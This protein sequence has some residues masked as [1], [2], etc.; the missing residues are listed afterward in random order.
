MPGHVHLLGHCAPGQ[1][2]LVAERLDAELAVGEHR[3]DLLAGVVELVPGGRWALRVEAGLGEDVLVPVEHPLRFQEQGVAVPGAV[4]LGDLRCGLG[5][6]LE[7]LGGHQIIQGQV[8]AQ[9]DAVV[10]PARDRVDVRCGAGRLGGGHLLVP[11]IAGNHSGV[12]E[13]LV[14][15][16]VEVLHHLFVPLVL[17]SGERV[18]P[19]LHDLAVPGLRI[20]VGGLAG[21]AAAARGEQGGRGQQSCSDAHSAPCGWG[22]RSFSSLRARGCRRWVGGPPG[23]WVSPAAGDVARP[24]AAPGRRP[25]A[26]GTS[27][28]SRTGHRCACSRDRARC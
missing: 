7:R 21:G 26:P 19:E 22:H 20:L 15:G 13:D 23:G 4:H 5:D 10:E 28:R 8:A 16:G 9:P 17:R 24:A 6:L 14:L 27:R 18:V 3:L 11:G 25:A 1:S 2:V 12:D